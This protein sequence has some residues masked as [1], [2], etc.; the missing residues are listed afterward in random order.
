[1]ISSL[2]HWWISQIYFCHLF[3]FLLFW[4]EN[5]LRT[6]S[7]L[8]HLFMLVL[9]FSIWS[10]LGNAPCAFQRSEFCSW[11]VTDGVTSLLILLSLSSSYFRTS[12]PLNLKSP[13]LMLSSQG[14]LVFF[15]SFSSLSPLYYIDQCSLLHGGSSSLF[16]SFSLFFTLSI[17]Q[18][19][20]EQNWTWGLTQTQNPL[21][22][23][24]PL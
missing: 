13:S 6:I 4:L 9:W 12:H 24:M 11:R 21:P 23:S 22:F 14:F 2:T 3:L 16:S 1:M 15:P 17:I 8:L 18:I 19:L 5:I 10:V 7:A 20:P